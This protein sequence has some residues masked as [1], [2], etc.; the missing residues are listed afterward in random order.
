MIGVLVM[1]ETKVQINERKIRN[2]I[3]KEKES[4]ERKMW[5]KLTTTPTVD[6]PNPLDPHITYKVTCS[7]ERNVWYYPNKP[8]DNKFD[9]VIINEWVTKN[10]KG[11]V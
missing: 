3:C 5:E 11:I 9:K 4:R 6:K 1:S 7:G 8:S 2:G 10:D